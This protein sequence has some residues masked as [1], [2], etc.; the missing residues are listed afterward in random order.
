MRKIRQ[1]LR[2]V[3]GKQGIS[4]KRRQ[5]AGEVKGEREVKWGSVGAHRARKIH[6]DTSEVSP[7]CKAAGAQY[8]ALWQ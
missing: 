1:R 4:C 2:V 5:D 7:E 3:S 6:K 8:Q